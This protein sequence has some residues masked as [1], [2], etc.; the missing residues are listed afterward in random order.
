MS[1]EII[2]RLIRALSIMKKTDATEEDA[3]RQVGY[4]NTANFSRDMKDLETQV[5]FWA[6]ILDQVEKEELLARPLKD[7]IRQKMLKTKTEKA[8]KGYY[9]SGASPFG[10]NIEKGGVLVQNQDIKRAEGVLRGFLAG[11][12][13]AQLGDEFHLSKKMVFL[14]LRSRFYIGEFVFR[15]KTYRGNWTPIISRDEFEEIQRRL[16]PRKGGV[17]H[18]GYQWLD[19]KQVLRPGAKEAYEEI[20]RMH[21]KRVSSTEIGKKFGL[22]GSGIRRLIKYRKITGKIE[23]QGSLVNSGLEQAIDE[24]TWERAQKIVPLAGTEWRAEK[25]RKLRSE[26]LMSMPAYRWELEQKLGVSKN[27]ILGNVKKM[28]GYEL[29]EREDG[30]LQ[31]KRDPFPEKRVETRFRTESLKRQKILDTLRSEGP[32]RTSQVAHKIGSRH[33][34]VEYNVNNL[35]AEGFIK[36]ENKGKKLLHLVSQHA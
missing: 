30:L 13:Q 3:A 16:P 36:K 22:S 6:P 9:V 28:V 14:I 34:T 15:G 26:I 19:G 33:S 11:K 17:L 27:T 21:L 2:E 8:E 31:M 25:A 35:I 7:E 18:F 10:Y 4:T 20:F 1:P 23:V 29:K 32:L 24:K 5:N 12:R